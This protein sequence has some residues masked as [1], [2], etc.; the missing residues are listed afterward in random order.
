M[1]NQ[2]LENIIIIK[3]AEDGPVSMILAG[4]HGNEKSGVH[5][6]EKILPNLVIKKGSLIIAY[7]S[8]EAL[9]K[10]VRY[11]DANLNRMFKPIEQLTALERMSYEFK[12]A[13]E[14]KPYLDKAGALLDIHT[15]MTPGSIPFVIC[16]QNAIEIIKYFPVDIVVSGFDTVEQGGSDY[17]MNTH[18]KIGICLEAGY[19]DDPRS[20][21]IAE[22]SIQRFI[23]VRGHDSTITLYECDQQKIH[24]DSLYT[25]QTDSFILNKDFQ[26]FEKIVKGQLIG[27]DGNKEIKAEDDCIILF[28]RNR[29]KTGEEAFLLGK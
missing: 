27:T 10:N 6:L 14:L 5:A 8:P 23:S 12:R 28:A 19:I 15:N 16:E 24:I 1:Q 21:E 2:N 26:N 4:V 25:T 9:R 7:G 22:E 3:G 29:Y 11:I 18:G 20:V 17:Y 13:E